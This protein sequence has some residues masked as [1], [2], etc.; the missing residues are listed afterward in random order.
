MFHFCIVAGA[1]QISGAA[2][3]QN[4]PAQ[5]D[6]GRVVLASVVDRQNRP[7]VTLGADDLVVTENGQSR[8]VLD[9]HI[10]D[11]PVVVLVDARAEVAATLPAMRAA[12]AR[13]IAR[14]GERPVGVGRL[15]DAALAASF[16]DDRADVLKRVDEISVCPASANGT[17]Q[18]VASAARAIAAA[19]VPFSSIV[20]LAA[21]TVGAGDAVGPEL[22][23]STLESGA[24]VQVVTARSPSDAP[25]APAADLLAVLARQTH[26]QYT[27]IY[28][29]DSYAIA[30]DRIA[31]RMATEMMIEY[32]APPRSNPGDVKVGARV[33][34]AR[35]VGLGVREIRN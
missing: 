17:M 12:V 4:S 21:H 10:A 5:A 8:Q 9:V 16:E 19:A 2:A 31:D 26:G 1:T 6:V 24:S 18:A 14:V 30:L 23:A 29:A 35:V 13:F 32:V 7:L 27:P 25:S 3:A 34:G 22:V 11:Y 20:I 28:S 33:P 15:C